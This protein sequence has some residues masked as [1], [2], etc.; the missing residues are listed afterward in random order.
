[1]LTGGASFL[2]QSLWGAPADAGRRADLWETSKAALEAVAVGFQRLGA[3]WESLKAAG[4]L[5][6]ARRRARGLPALS[7]VP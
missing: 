2:C 3:L 1:V 4:G 6:S 5:Y 7:G